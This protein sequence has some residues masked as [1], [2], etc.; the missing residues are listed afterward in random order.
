VPVLELV[1]HL[2]ALVGLD[3]RPRPVPGSNP[4][5]APRLHWRIETTW[6]GPGGKP[7]ARSVAALDGGDDGWWL[8]GE[9]AAQPQ[10]TTATELFR[11]LC[12]LLPTDA[13][14]G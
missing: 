10:P 9:E 3:P 2:A 11:R 1:T 6:H 7:A 13:E 12:R 14:L 8:V 4:P 5:S